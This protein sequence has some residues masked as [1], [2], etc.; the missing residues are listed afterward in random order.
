MWVILRINDINAIL[1]FTD[2]LTANATM[3]SPVVRSYFDNLLPDD[4]ASSVWTSITTG[5]K[6]QAAAF[7]KDSIAR[8]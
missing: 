8:D 3:T 4:F 2:N 7:L 5:R 1:F 6:R